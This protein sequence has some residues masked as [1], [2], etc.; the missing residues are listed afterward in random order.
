MNIKLG[1]S[2]ERNNY[3]QMSCFDIIIIREILITE[4]LG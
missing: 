1:N 2:S 3:Y 4:I